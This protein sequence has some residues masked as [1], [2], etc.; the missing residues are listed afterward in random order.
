MQ[1][2]GRR[3]RTIDGNEEKEKR[4]MNSSKTREKIDG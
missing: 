2:S 1:M 3:Q 4:S